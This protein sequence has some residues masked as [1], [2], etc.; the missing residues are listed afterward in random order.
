MILWKDHESCFEPVVLSVWIE[1][2]CKCK[3]GV[4][5]HMMKWVHSEFANPSPQELNNGHGSKH[6]IVLNLTAILSEE[7][8]PWPFGP[9]RLVKWGC[10]YFR[11]WDSTL[12]TTFMHTKPLFAVW[13]L[14]GDFSYFNL[15]KR[16]RIPEDVMT[17][18][19]DLKTVGGRAPDSKTMSNQDNRM[20]GTFV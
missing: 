10:R 14:Y 12:H 2:L 1:V 7:Q 13:G 8:I 15:L 16:K 5:A 17:V 3:Q 18:C 6:I 11:V 9:H 20:K 19:F 4:E